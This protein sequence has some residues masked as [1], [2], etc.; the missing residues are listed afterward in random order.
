MIAAKLHLKG[1]TGRC[2]EF[3]GWVTERPSFIH[4]NSLCPQPSHGR[5]SPA[6]FYAMET[7]YLPG[8]FQPLIS[9]PGFR[10][11]PPFWHGVSIGSKFLITSSPASYL[12]GSHT[13]SSFALLNCVFRLYAQDIVLK[14]LFHQPS[15]SSLGT[16]SISLETV[17]CWPRAHRLH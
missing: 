11:C 8:F 4:L 10:L 6:H 9:F 16:L 7:G 15:M 3:L 14:S 1:T 13:L 5:P 2:S 17:C 12:D